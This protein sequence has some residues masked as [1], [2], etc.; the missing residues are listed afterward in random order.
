MS[1]EMVDMVEFEATWSRLER[2]VDLLQDET[3]IC[4]DEATN[5]SPHWPVM[6]LSQLKQR[7]EEVKSLIDMANSQKPKSDIYASY[8]TYMLRKELKD[9]KII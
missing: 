5:G 3:K 7:V 4:L 6:H 2:V 9:A 8:E 1:H